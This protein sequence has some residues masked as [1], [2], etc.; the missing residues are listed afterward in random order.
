M[1]LNQ[2]QESH[3]P[4]GIRKLVQL[5]QNNNNKKMK[6]AWYAIGSS[7]DCSQI[8]FIFAILKEVDTIYFQTI[9]AQKKYIFAYPDCLC[10]TRFYIN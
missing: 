5:K 4:K 7:G 3:A 6:Q 1:T 8:T 9:V 10:E 2:G